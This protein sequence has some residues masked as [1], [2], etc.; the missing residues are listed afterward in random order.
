MDYYVIISQ[1]TLLIYFMR[2]DVCVIKLV[3]PSTLSFTEL[4]LHVCDAIL[5]N[6]GGHEVE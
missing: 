3:V 6:I 4:K 1:P 2:V 5:L